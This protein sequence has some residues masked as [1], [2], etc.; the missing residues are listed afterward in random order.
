MEIKDDG[1]ERH[2]KAELAELETD[3]GNRGVDREQGGTDTV[4]GSLE[5][6][7]FRGR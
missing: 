6:I 2:F 4:E 5:T 7:W 1:F 3:C